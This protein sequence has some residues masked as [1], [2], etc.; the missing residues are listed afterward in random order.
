MKKFL[1]LALCMVLMGALLVG[2]GAPTTEQSQPAA[3]TEVDAIGEKVLRIATP[4]NYRPFTIFD[5]STETWSGFEIDLWEEI[6]TRIGFDVEYIRIDIP[7]A[8]GEV[9]IGKADTLQSR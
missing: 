1:S 7:G 2:C 3:E 4:G 9:D 8:F 5:E 6:G